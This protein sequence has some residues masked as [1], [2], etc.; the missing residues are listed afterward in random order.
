MPHQPSTE[1]AEGSSARD[2]L[3][4]GLLQR[5][6][7]TSTSQV[8]PAKQA[9]KN[10]KVR[11][12]P[13]VGGKRSRS[14]T[15]MD[16]M[17]SKRHARDPPDQR[18]EETES[19]TQDH[20]E[21]DVSGFLHADEFDLH[22]ADFFSPADNRESSSPWTPCSG[23]SDSLEPCSG[24]DKNDPFWGEDLSTDVE[25]AHAEQLDPESQALVDSFC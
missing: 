14:T 19:C 1:S 8:E 7:Q 6:A 9:G 15:F 11:Q 24:D 17:L 21:C 22:G 18:T 12:V 3:R 16:V 13:K 25:L 20:S 2:R 23:H 10:A 4:A 5:Q